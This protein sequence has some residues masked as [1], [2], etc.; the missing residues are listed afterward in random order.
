MKRFYA[1]ENGGQFTIMFLDN[2]ALAAGEAP[3]ADGFHPGTPVAHVRPLWVDGVL[4]VLNATPWP[5]GFRP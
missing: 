5:E 4:K 3:D 1:F 2:E